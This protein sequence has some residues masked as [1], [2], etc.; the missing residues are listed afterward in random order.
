MKTHL[1][2]GTRFRTRDRPV[3][4]RLETATGISSGLAI[5]ISVGACTLR[6]ITRRPAHTNESRNSRVPVASA[7]A[8]ADEESIFA[9]AKGHRRQPAHGRPAID[10][11]SRSTLT[12][13]KRVSRSRGWSVRGERR[14]RRREGGGGGDVA[15]AE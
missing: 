5:D 3:S 10:E 12:E 1:I 15:A 14:R 7:A 13:R 11:G 4:A 2:L 9:R 8:A 6:Y